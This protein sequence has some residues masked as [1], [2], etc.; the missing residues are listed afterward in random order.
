M[1]VKPI[2]D[3]YH[4]VT[5]YLVVRD[6]ATAIEFYKKAFSATEL[7]RLPMPEGKIGHAEIKIGDSHIMLADEC[8]ESQAASPQTLKGTTFGLCIYVEDCDSVYAQAIAAGGREIR[9]VAD[10]FYGDRSGTLADPFGH[11]W[12]IG[13][14]KEDVTPEEI[15]QRM[16][17]LMAQQAAT[18]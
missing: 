5:P 6:G 9:P 8:P 7:F 3:G 4:S 10:Q 11:Q 15:N 17:D 16:A 13:T 14:H 12:T 18:T 2:P 1:S